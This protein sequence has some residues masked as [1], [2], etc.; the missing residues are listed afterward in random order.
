MPMRFEA[1]QRDDPEAEAL[2]RSL[3]RVERREHTPVTPALAP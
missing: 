3:T 2:M 1:L